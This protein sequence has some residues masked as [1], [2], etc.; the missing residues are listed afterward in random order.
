MVRSGKEE[1]K[2]N[3]RIKVADKSEDKCEKCN[4]SGTD[5]KTGEK[6][7]HCRGKGYYSQ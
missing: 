5:T 7:D 1:L 2:I 3:R 4:G 6:C